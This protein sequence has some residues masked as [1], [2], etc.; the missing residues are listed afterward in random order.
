MG[1]FFVLAIMGGAFLEAVVFLAALFPISRL[2]IQLLMF[3]VSVP[4]AGGG[5]GVAI[6]I[7]AASFAEIVVAID[8]LCY[9]PLSCSLLLPI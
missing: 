9:L 5:G 8:L 2:S 1:V 4:V 6:P 7:V 3:I